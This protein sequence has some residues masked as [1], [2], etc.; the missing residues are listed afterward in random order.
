MEQCCICYENNKFL[1]ISCNHKV[2]KNC[3]NKMHNTKCPICR[4]DFKN[5]I[6][7][8]LKEL[9]SQNKLSTYTYYYNPEQ[10]NLNENF[11]LFLLLLFGLD[12]YLNLPKWIIYIF[13][14]CYLRKINL[15]TLINSFKYMF[16]LSKKRLNI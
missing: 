15:K 12:Y 16:I 2:C 1:K 7:K 10:N 3:C 5:D 9:I 14:F 8:K 6:S 4:K 11:G 13:V